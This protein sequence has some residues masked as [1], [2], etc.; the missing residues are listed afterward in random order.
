MF[1]ELAQKLAKELIE[2]LDGPV[3]DH[4]QKLLEIDKKAEL[5]KYSKNLVIEKE[6]FAM[7][8][9]NCHR[10]GY[11]HAR[12]TKDFVPEHLHPNNEEVASLSSIKTGETLSKDALKFV[13]KISQSFKQRRL[14]VAH[15]FYNDSQWHI[16][17]F[18]QRDLEDFEKNHWKE[19]SHIHFVNYLWPDYNPSDL[20]VLFD[21]ANA[22]IGGKIHIR[23]LQER[24]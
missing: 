19:G 17:Y 8:V 21:K 5:V 4:L 2:S 20:W 11:R 9:H 22:S 12:K 13:Q 10:I 7:L 23:F 16:F 18:D 1:E 24:D 3:P 14:L 6:Q 15:V